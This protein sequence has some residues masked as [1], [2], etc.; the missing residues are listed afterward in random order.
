VLDNMLQM[1]CHP[2]TPSK[3]VIAVEVTTELSA[4]GALWF[5]FYVDGV[6]DA[7]ET[8][9]PTEPLR[10]NGLWQTTCFEAF[11][12]QRGESGY[13]EY[14]FAPSGAWAAYQFDGYREGV[15]DLVLDETPEILLDASE[16]HLAAEVTITVPALLLSGAID[17]NLTA[18][19]E[20][21]D[22]IKSYWA[23]AHPPGKPDFHHRDCFALK[24]S[25]PVAP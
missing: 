11:L 7:L 24:L 15:R 3:T 1:V 19:I 25:A 21:T 23:L 6:L 2:D 12:S 8:L 13:C 5:R 10:T 14:N 4:S 20:E 17:L 18:V 9:E 22:G 16:T